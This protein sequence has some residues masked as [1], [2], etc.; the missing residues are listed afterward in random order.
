M[1]PLLSV[2]QA[3]ASIAQEKKQRELGSSMILPSDTTA[4]AVRGSHHNISKPRYNNLDQGNQDSDSHIREPFNCTYCWDLYHKEA[5]P[6]ATK[7][8]AIHLVTL[9]EISAKAIAAIPP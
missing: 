1:N 9:H 7:R 5:R 8:M 2:L 3:Y 4:M 6:H